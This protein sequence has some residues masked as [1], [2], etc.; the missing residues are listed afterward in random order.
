MQMASCFKSTIVILVTACVF[1]AH[2]AHAQTTALVLNSAPGDYIGGGVNQTFTEADGT[3]MPTRNFGSSASI[4]FNGGP[5]WWYLDFAA[6][7]DAPLAVGVY[8]D[9]TRFPFQSPTKPGLSI[10]GEGR[11]CN[12]LNGRFEVLEIV[13]GPTGDVERF[14]ATFEQHCEGMEP[15]LTGSILFNSTLPG[16]PPPT[17]RCRS[18]VAT[19]A[20][21]LGEVSTL[22][23]S[24]TAVKMLRRPLQDAQAAVEN[25]RPRQAR[26][27]M[28]LFTLNAVT[29]SS[30]PLRNPHRIPVPASNSL[31]CGAANVLINIAAP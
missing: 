14:A 20:A 29:L 15:A 7:I 3:F 23:T 28:A 31:V 9:A 22:E 25:G 13:Y 8:E 1:G 6:P 2:A 19:A 5:H 12:Q 26:Q 10:W 21:L 18:A 11:G 27:H 17:V 30:L 24:R 16:P 4:F